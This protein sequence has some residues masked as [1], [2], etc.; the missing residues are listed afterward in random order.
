MSESNTYGLTH[1]DTLQIYEK[2]KDDKGIKI[3][4]DSSGER[5]KTGQ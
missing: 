4:D 5:L 2:K 3:E 1:I